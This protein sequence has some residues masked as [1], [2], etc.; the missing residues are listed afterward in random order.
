MGS[1]QRVALCLC[2][3]AL[4]LQAPSAQGAPRLSVDQFSLLAERLHS[5]NSFKVRLQ[6]ALLL[7]VAGGADAE[8]LLVTALQRDPDLAVRAAAAL[9]LGETQDER[10]FDPLIGALG[11]EDQL[12]RTQAEK[13]LTELSQSVNEG[14]LK[15]WGQLARVPGVVQERGIAVLGNLGAGGVVAL[16]AAAT[17]GS[18]AT[19][20]AAK[21]ELSRLPPD[22]LDAGLRATL[23]RKDSDTSP[24]AAAM[25][26]DMGTPRSLPV[27]ADAM[28]D[29]TQPAAVQ[30]E[31]RSS[32]VRL[33]GIIDPTT[34][35]HH[36][37]SDDPQERLRAVVLLAIK[38]GPAA[39]ALSLRALQ[40]SNLRVQAAGASAS[41]DLG[42]T[43]ALPTIKKLLNR[44]EEAPIIRILEIAARRL[45]RKQQ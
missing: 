42:N 4:A 11:D 35:A 31:A 18:D 38:G 33:S 12:L 19:K 16:C 1:K 10:A 34:E 23:R 13:G 39:E 40:D 17:S 14:P 27:L 6:A 25:L 21:A 30:V 43:Q 9:A 15:L 28:S 22:Q 36:F 41:A 32:L 29:A 7:G 5:S 37:E 26:G 3:A 20:A 45:E 2:V 44:E 8:P 24:L